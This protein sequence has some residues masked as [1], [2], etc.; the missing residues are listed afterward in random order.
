MGE[1]P[2]G[3]FDIT[4]GGEKVGR[5]IFEL[6]ADIVPKTVENFRC[7]VTGERGIGKKG[8]PLHYKGCT[9][10]RI[11][12]NFMIQGGDFTNHNG[13]GG[14]SIYGENFD[15]E[16][17]KLKHTKPGILSMANAGKNTNSSQFFITTTATPHLDGKH[18]V[19]GEVLR[20][21]GVVRALENVETSGSSKPKLVCA[22]SDCG[23][24]EPGADISI[25]VEDDGTGDTFPEYP[26]DTEISTNDI[27]AML[28]AVEKLRLIGNQQFKENKLDVAKKKY[29]KALRYYDTVDMAT[30]ES[31]SP[32]DEKQLFKAQLPIRLNLG[33]CYLQ[34]KQYEDTIA[35]CNKA[36]DLD[37]ESAKGWF[38]RGKAEMGM[39]LYEQAVADFEATLLREPDNKAAKNELERA[40]QFV[41]DRRKR[42]KAAYAKMFSSETLQ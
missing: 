35:Q 20:G 23:M 3:F 13:T 31:R 21:M 28:E 30:K 24:L 37:P 38:R 40:K 1:N 6:F 7:L 10:H 11:I 12:K 41:R 5:I 26:E 2:R 16:N 34:L 36:L 8:K 18:T 25:K 9:F 29:E 33:A 14:E 32:E 27:T 39:K 19:F 42:E 15:D 4:I 22:I 17:F